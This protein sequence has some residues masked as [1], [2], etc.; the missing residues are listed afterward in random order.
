M[1]CRQVT[2]QENE[3]LIFDI[4]ECLKDGFYG[5]NGF[6]K[7]L[8]LNLSN[9]TVQYK[10]SETTPIVRAAYIIANKVYS[11]YRDDKQNPKYADDIQNDFTAFLLLP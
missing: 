9:V 5:Q 10:N 4:M 6:I 7:P 11:V 2:E 8:L 1:D 3:A